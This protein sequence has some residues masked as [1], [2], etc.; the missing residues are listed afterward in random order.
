MY[1]ALTLLLL[2]TVATATGLALSWHRFLTVPLTLE[3]PVTVTIAP[4]AAAGVIAE[5]M[6]QAGLVRNARAFRLLARLRGADREFRHGGHTFEGRLL[7]DDVLSELVRHT[8]G[9]IRVTIPEGR[10]LYEVAAI[11]EES[12][13]VSADDYVAAACDPELLALCGA[14]PSGHCA[15]G[16]LFPETYNFAPSMTAE[17]IVRLQVGQFRRVMR[18]VLEGVGQALPDERNALLPQ[19]ADRVAYGGVLAAEPAQVDIVRDIVTLASIVEKETGVGEER[20]LVAS[21][22]HNRLRIGMR[23]QADPT[24]I[25]GL[26]IS[27]TPWERERLHE[28][29]REPGP[30]NTYT[31]PG[32]PPGPICNPGELALRAAAAPVASKYLYFVANLDGTHRFSKSLAEHNRAIAEVRRLARQAS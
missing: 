7:P 27:G 20:P 11:L 18:G 4:G 32:L 5:D 24:V 13:I 12:G 2:F 26:E 17:E 30:Y 8:S 6:A 29:L 15:E 10:T 16:Y 23:L 22:F 19:P 28:Y 31:E 21:V 1:R 25:Y 3:A 14:A 9:T